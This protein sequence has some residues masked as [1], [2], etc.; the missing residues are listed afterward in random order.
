[1]IYY[2]LPSK[3]CDTACTLQDSNMTCMVSTMS[4]VHGRMLNCQQTNPHNTMAIVMMTMM[5]LQ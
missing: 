2:L 1:M 4:A 5:P 3:T